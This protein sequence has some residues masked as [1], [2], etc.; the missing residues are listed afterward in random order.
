[1]ERRPGSE[2][3]RGELFNPLPTD[4]F[5]GMLIYRNWIYLLP[6]RFPAGGHIASV[7]NLRQKNFRWH[8]SRQ[9]ALESEN[10]TEAWDPADIESI[11]RIAEVLMFHDA[12]GGTRYTTLRHG[13]LSF[14]D[15][16]HVL[17]DDRC[18]LMGRV[19][20]PATRFETTI[21]GSTTEPSG[22]RMTILRVVLPVVDPQRQK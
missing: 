7:D 12:V 15:L 16:S 14:L 8:L 3:L 22:T 1:V 13:P 19:A 10:E 6:T 11:D 17:S 9:K 18:I 21:D 4:L 5:N 2:L 20:D